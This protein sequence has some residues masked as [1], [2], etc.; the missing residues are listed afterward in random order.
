MSESNNL[1][2][3][4]SHKKLTYLML[5]AQKDINSINEEKDFISQEKQEFDELIN[6]WEIIS[7]DVIKTISKRNKDLLKDKS[8]NSLIALGAMEV[9]VNMA[10]QALNAFKKDS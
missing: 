6:K 5:N 4:I 7:K 2:Q 1:P 8:S 3:A 9:H 10:L